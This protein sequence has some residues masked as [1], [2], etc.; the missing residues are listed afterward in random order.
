VT[1]DDEGWVPKSVAVS[2][3]A[4]VHLDF[5]LPVVEFSHE[6]LVSRVTR[7]RIG[8]VLPSTGAG[9]A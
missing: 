4:A 2:S 1:H 6:Q 8:M 7:A 5:A 9:V 3:R